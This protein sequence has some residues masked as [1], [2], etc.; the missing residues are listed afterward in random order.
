VQLGRETAQRLRSRG[1]DKILEDVY[2]QEIAA[3]AQP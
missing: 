1:A 3:P 2:G